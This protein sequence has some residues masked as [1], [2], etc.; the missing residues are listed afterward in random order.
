VS[1]YEPLDPLLEDLV[2]ADKAIALDEEPPMDAMRTRLLLSIGVAGAAVGAT[3]VA[4]AAATSVAETA[5]RTTAA[6]AL[7]AKVIAAVAIASVSAGSGALVQKYRDDR[8]IAAL[9]QKL[10]VAAVAPPLPAIAPEPV[11]AP[12]PPARMQEAAPAPPPPPA[13]RPGS[14][15]PRKDADLQ[16][17]RRLIEGARTALLRREPEHALSSL[18]AHEKR[19]KLGRLAE[20]RDSLR[21]QALAALGKAPQARAAAAA[22]H[23]R[24]PES[25]FGPAVDGTIDRMQI[26]ASE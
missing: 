12:S 25:F 9:E 1:H 5:V 8:K 2:D 22:F 15:A 16:A 24:Y 18:S 21:V 10:A 13:T 3:S 20:E 7:K 11:P 17:E 14:E 23:E 26:G 19:F 4:A 6:A